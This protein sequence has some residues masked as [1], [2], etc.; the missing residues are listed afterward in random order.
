MPGRCAGSAPPPIDM[1]TQ[2]DV[3]NRV[4]ARDERWPKSRRLRKRGE[5]L[6][7]Q[8]IGRRRGSGRLVV[9]CAASRRGDSRLGITV[10]RKVGN[11]VTRNRIKRWVREVFRRIRPAVQPAQDILVIARPEAAAASYDDVRAEMLRALR[12][13]E[14]R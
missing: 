4:A 11:A 13:A 7:M 1:P 12:I 9:L 14:A 10:S 6:R 8:R 2:D 5:Y 3:P